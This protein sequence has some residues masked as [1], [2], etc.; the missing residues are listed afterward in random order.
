MKTRSCAVDPV[1]SPTGL[2]RWPCLTF[3]LTVAG[4]PALVFSFVVVAL[5]M[6]VHAA[7]QFLKV[8][9]PGGTNTSQ[10]SWA[11]AWGDYDQDGFL[12][13]LVPNTSLSWGAWVNFLYHNNGDGTFTK[14]LAAEVGPIASDRDPSAG[15]YWGDINNDGRLDLLVGNWPASD[16]SPPGTNRVYLNLGNG[17]F[18]S[19]DAGDL[20]KS[21]YTFGWANLADYDNDGWLDAFMIAAWADSGHRTNLLY[22]ARGDGKFDLVTSGVVA[23]DTSPMSLDASWSDFDNDGD[24]DLLVGNWDQNNPADDFFYRNEG[25]GQFTRLTNSVLENYASATGHHAW[26]DYDND[27][28][29]DVATGG[30]SPLCLFRNT[31]NGE[32]ELT[33]TISTSGNQVWADYDNDGFLDMVV[34]RGQGNPL[35]LLLFHSDRNGG[36]DEV[37]DAFTRESAKWIMGAWSDYD[38]DGFLD[39]FVAEETGQNALFHNLGNANHW[40]K[41]VLEGT[42]AN[43]AAIGAKVRIEA[44]IGGKTVRQMREVSSDYFTPDGLRPSFGLGDATNVDV[45]RIEWPS[46]IVQ[47]L[48]D[49]A[50]DQLLSIA[51]PAVILPVRPTAGLG[52]SITLQ[53]RIS[54]NI[55]WYHE[56]VALEGETNRNLTLTNVAL[57]DAGRYWVVVHT[58]TGDLTNFTYLA[59]D[60]RFEK[61]SQGD[62]VSDR[63]RSTQGAWGDYDADGD[64]DLAVAGGY[65]DTSGATNSGLYRNDGTGNLVRVANTPLASNQDRN[66]YLGWADYDNDG[67]LD[68]AVAVHES[69]P[70]AL[71]LNQGDGQFIKQ[72]ASADWIL[73]GL[74]ARGA[75]TA[76]GD[77]DSDGRV[78]L[79]VINWVAGGGPPDP[80]SLLHNAGNGQ[81]EVDTTSALALEN[82]SEETIAWINFDHD[83]DLDF[84]SVE[85]GSSTLIRQ[86][87]RNLGHGQFE[88]ITDSPFWG[89]RRSIHW[90]HVWADLDSDNDFDVLAC[91]GG[92]DA[93]H[94]TIFLNDQHGNLTRADLAAMNLPADFGAIPAVGD[95][96]NDGYLDLFCAGAEGKRNR[97]FN[98][99]GDEHF[100]EILT[101]GIP[102]LQRL[103]LPSGLG[104]L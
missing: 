99:R 80:N 51:E 15:A 77:Y 39:L 1:T 92:T 53:S 65:W 17:T 6:S 83:G 18:A 61:I 16:S 101:G 56:G 27:G 96:D 98:N 31:G 36:F 91:V 33:R 75:T 62:V 73:N 32:F 44:T 47:E 70:M 37:E 25:D 60:S 59:V 30:L 90:G 19:A 4:R 12:D 82:T 52:D 86:L 67:D 8:E 42:V 102:D 64:L 78:D 35:E 46:G 3:W 38:N 23:T 74:A 103:Q 43:R 85:S 66:C 87:F 2:G 72:R 71:Y 14:K 11:G 63:F 81:F 95:F 13:L 22:H 100:E 55:Q 45:V 20:T 79:M 7:D 48:E 89:E 9:P 26:G 57:A 68:L 76:W 50:A 94:D 5:T 28:W 58:T 24:V 88:P 54:R 29:M 21:T 69:T 34:I 104:R 84:S 93:A 10:Y 97:L 40:I 49:V 41:F